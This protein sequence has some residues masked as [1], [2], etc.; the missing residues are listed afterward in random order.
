[1]YVTVSVER[2]RKKRKRKKRRRRISAEGS[3]LVTEV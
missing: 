2:R 1:M 3:H